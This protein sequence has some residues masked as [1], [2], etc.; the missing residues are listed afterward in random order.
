MSRWVK[1][2]E[3]TTRMGKAIGASLKMMV[4]AMKS[5]SRTGTAI[6]ISVNTMPRAM[7]PTSRIVSAIKREHLEASLAMVK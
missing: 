1:G 4:K 6:G 5:T 7:R 3:P 2:S